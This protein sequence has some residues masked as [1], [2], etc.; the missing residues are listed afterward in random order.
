MPNAHPSAGR[1]WP[2]GLRRER[3]SRRRLAALVAVLVLAV[4]S[5][6]TVLAQGLGPAGPSPA[7]GHA[8]VVAHGVATLA[9]SNG[10]WHIT[11]L[12]AEAGGDPIT[13]T[14]P[15]FAI[16]E[17][18][19]L[20]LSDV[21][22][23]S[24]QRLAGGEALMLNAGA[25]V[26]AETFGAPDD[27]LFIQLI[28][29]DARPAAGS[30]EDV[31]TSAAFPVPEGDRD[32]DLLRDVIAEGETTTIPAGAIP[33]GVYVFRG[34]VTVA[35]AGEETPLRSGEAGAFAGELEITAI[36]D[37]SVVYA[38]YAGSSVPAATPRA[39]PA[40]ATPVPT[41]VPPTP[42]PTPVPPT[43]EP[44]AVP[45]TP[46]PT[47]D[48]A[49]DDEDGV[50]NARE[51]ELG[52]DP[53]N[54]DTDDDGISD[55]EEINTYRTNP[56]LMDTDEDLLYDG[57][58]LVYGTDPMVADT[59]GDGVSDGAEVY[60][61]ETNPTSADSD[62]DGTPDGVE[63]N[64]GTDPRTAPGQ[65]PTPPPAESSLDSDGDG[66]TDAQEARIGTNSGMNDTDG[67]GV[68]DSN[69]VAAGT[70]PLDRTSY[71]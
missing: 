70:N 26:T 66:L 58:E 71:P 5:L 65:A 40:P 14:V 33:T 3:W 27:F 55:G 48:T 9:D 41:A 47:P 68:N 53:A 49:D 13:V 62:G 8:S 1:P 22:T 36:A 25:Q 37:G 50:T 18:T 44:T 57:G 42:T 19:P 69:E 29:G 63:I 21:D 12:V 59:D 30:A 15:G 31:F 23:G 34:E 51:V 2:A 38:A 61:Y 17:N 4:P 54:P 67:D 64:N 24:R 28:S 35:A 16:A 60:I 6:A 7:T 11:R 46:E 39:T 52:L 43:S 45:P 10:R 20:L 56:R 32:L